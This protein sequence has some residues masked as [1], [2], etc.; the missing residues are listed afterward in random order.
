MRSVVATERPKDPRPQDAP[1]IWKHGIL[2]HFVRPPR[3][4]RYLLRLQPDGGARLAI[5]RRGSRAEAMRFLERSE[6]WLVKRHRQWRAQSAERQPWQDGSSF[7]FRGEEIRLSAKAPHAGTI[8]SFADQ[9][10]LDVPPAADYRAIV[11]E[12]L[13]GGRPVERLRLPDSCIN[14]SHCPHRKN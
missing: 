9:V 14:T 10:L 5:P 6:A 8:L 12:H 4:R 11:Q 13:L 2:V 3:L 1:F 7:L